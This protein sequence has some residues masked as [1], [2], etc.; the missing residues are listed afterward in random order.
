MATNERT[1]ITVKPDGVHGN[2]IE[3]IIQRFEQRVCKFVDLNMIT[4]SMEHL[5]VHY[6]YLR[7]KPPFFTHL[8]KYMGSGLV[9]AMIWQGLDVVK[10]GLA[11][12][13]AT[14]PLASA[15]GMNRGD[16]CIQTVVTAVTAL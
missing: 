14:H 13:G 6:Q 3:K 12:L 7:D 16:F 1:L 10:Q 5:E 11:K 4:A 15:P 8:I 9:V 2:L